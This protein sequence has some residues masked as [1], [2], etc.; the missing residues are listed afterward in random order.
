MFVKLIFMIISG[1]I[2]CFSVNN[3]GL[4]VN[5]VRDRFASWIVPL[6]A[7]ALTNYNSNLDKELLNKKKYN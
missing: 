1:I 2:L 3:D 6:E 7:L 5:E 4:C